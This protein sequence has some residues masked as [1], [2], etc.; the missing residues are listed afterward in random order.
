MAENE[1]NLQALKLEM[2]GVEEGAIELG[3]ADGVGKT[4]EGNIEI[5]GG[6]QKKYGLFFNIAQ[7]CDNY[8]VGQK[9]A[10]RGQ[11]E[12]AADY[13]LPIVLKVFK[14]GF[15]LRDLEKQWARGMLQNEHS[16]GRSGAN[17]MFFLSKSQSSLVGRWKVCI[18]HK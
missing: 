13:S 6:L 1:I 8:V 15:S 3:E 11:A 18:C 16:Q 9:I 14:G 2:N 5:L 10:E 7:E 4:A 12:R 17:F